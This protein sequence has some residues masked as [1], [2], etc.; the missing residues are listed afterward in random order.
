MTN[1]QF[2]IKY[3]IKGYLNLINLESDP[4]SYE[5]S[6]FKI[7]DNIIFDLIKLDANNFLV[8]CDKNGLIKITEIS[9]SNQLKEKSILNS[10]SD[11]VR[12]LTQCPN[13]SKIASCSE[14]KTVRI[15]DINTLQQLSLIEGHGN[16]VTCVAWHPSLSF[17][18]SGSKD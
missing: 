2:I 9:L 7:H 5:L 8:S 15:W 4:L 3:N 16:D 6:Q 13:D 12:G 14:D 11:G 18:V 17:V 10:N 1:N